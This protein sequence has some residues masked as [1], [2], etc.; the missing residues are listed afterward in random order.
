MRWAGRGHTTG[1]KEPTKGLL[2]G[3]ARD[4]KREAVAAGT[5]LEWNESTQTWL[6]RRTEDGTRATGPDDTD[7]EG[8]SVLG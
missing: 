3:V 5:L 8:V 7:S 2:K 4:D 6:A 1:I